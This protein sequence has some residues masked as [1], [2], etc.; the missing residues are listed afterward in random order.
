MGQP[1]HNPAVPVRIGVE[2]FTEVTFNAVLRAVEAQKFPRG[3]IIY[4][5]IYMPEGLPA[6]AI[7]APRPESPS[8]AG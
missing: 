4:G 3:P 6:E 5:I 8:R 7:Q 1:A 2:E